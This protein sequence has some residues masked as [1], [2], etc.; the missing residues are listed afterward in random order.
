MVWRLRIF[1]PLLAV[2]LVALAVVAFAPAANPA[3]AGEATSTSPAL[4]EQLR[5]IGRDGVTGMPAPVDDRFIAEV[6]RAVE[7]YGKD[8]QQAVP[9]PPVRAVEVTNLAI[10]R[11]NVNASIARFGIDRFGRLDVP[12]D[13]RTVGWH[14]AYSLVPGEGSA[15][16]LAAHFEY[17]GRPGVFNQITTL[18]AGDELD[19]TLT[20]GSTHRYRVD[21]TIDYALGAIDMGAILYGREGTESVTLMTCSGPANEGEYPLRTVVLASR[22]AP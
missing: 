15:T 21:S 13:A 10:P 5:Y 11:L 16:F 9:P 3:A 14:P 4:G 17:A 20:D 7:R 2:P 12:Q 1:V 8:E 19:V 6:G 18:H 22:V